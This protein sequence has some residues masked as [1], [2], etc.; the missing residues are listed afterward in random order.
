MA[1]RPPEPKKDKPEPGTWIAF[2]LK[3]AAHA[4]DPHALP[5]TEAGNGSLLKLPAF[6]GAAS[7]L[8]DQYALAFEKVLS[9]TDLLPRAE[10]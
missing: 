1:T 7:G 4:Y 10:S 6:P 2:A 8:L 9:Q 5:R 3:E